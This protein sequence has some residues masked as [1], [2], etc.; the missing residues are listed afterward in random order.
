MHAAIEERALR[1]AASRSDS[2][3]TYAAY[4]DTSRALLGKVSVGVVTAAV[5]RSE[6][7][8]HV[9]RSAA[10]AAVMHWQRGLRR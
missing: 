7:S 4:R 10:I 9:W 1:E 6:T 2:D 5:R 3:G 8:L